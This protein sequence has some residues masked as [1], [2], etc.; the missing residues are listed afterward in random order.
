MYVYVCI[1]YTY[2]KNVSHCMYSIC[3]YMYNKYVYMYVCLMYIYS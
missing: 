2:S 1:M 3:M